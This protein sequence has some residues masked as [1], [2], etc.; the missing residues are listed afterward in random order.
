[1]VDNGN[2]A[3]ALYVMNSSGKMNVLDTLNR[4]LILRL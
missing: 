2:Q 1:M 3:N 4:T